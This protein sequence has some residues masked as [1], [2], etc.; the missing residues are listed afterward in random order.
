MIAIR[1]K[2]VG[3]KNLKKWRIIVTKSAAPRNGRLLEEIGFY[4]SLKN[5][6]ET[7]V[8]FD[9][10]EAWLKK[11]AQPSDTVRSLMKKVKK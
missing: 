10:Y 4:N 11:G 9:R 5:P 7:Q 6:P 1:L 8:K 3:T 2:Q